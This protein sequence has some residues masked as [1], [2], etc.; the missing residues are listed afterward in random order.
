MSPP[1]RRRFAWLA[2]PLAPLGLY[3]WALVVATGAGY[4]G[5]IGPA[6]N[7]L[8]CDWTIFYT[9]LE[10]WRHG[11]LADIYDQVWLGRAMQGAYEPW[12]VNPEPFPAFHYPPSWLL[13]IAP[14]AGLS[15][16][17][18]FAATQALSLAALLAALAKTYGR[19]LGQFAVFAGSLLLAPATSNNLLSGQNA[20]LVC[21]L[22]VV[23]FPLL[24]SQPLLAGALLG[25]ASFKPQIL[26]MAPFALLGARN[27]RAIVGA[28]ASALA[29]AAASALV[30][31]PQ[32]WL[33]W[34]ELMIHPRHDVA[35]TGVE[36]GRLWDDSV[37]TCAQLIGLSKA[38]ADLVQAAATLAAGAIVYASFRRPLASDQRFAIFLAAS[39]VAAPHVSPYDMM[40]AAL[41]ATIVAW[42]TVQADEAP[43]PVA[44]LLPLAAWLIPLYGPPR[45]DPIGLVTPLVLFGLMAQVLLAPQGRAARVRVA[46][47]AAV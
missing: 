20:A 5:R 12:L 7:G 42:R 31:G 9:A 1:L 13:L 28:G 33:A 23:G 17:A 38:A 18:S 46:P 11:H 19:R 44:L 14:F 41:A 22:I 21:A 16:I 40:L 47:A 43:R 26:L 36:W 10:A 34:I 24:E 45:A 2:L 15:M 29:L 25:L 35:M 27:W 39:V 3:G 4:N 37:Y 8:A 6:F 30:F 32:I